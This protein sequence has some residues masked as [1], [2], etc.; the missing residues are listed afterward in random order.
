MLGLLSVNTT[1][2]TVSRMDLASH[3]LGSACL[4][5]NR[6]P[7]TTRVKEEEREEINQLCQ[8][9]FLCSPSSLLTSDHMAAVLLL[10]S[11]KLLPVSD[12]IWNVLYLCI[13]M[14]DYCTISV[15]VAAE[16]SQATRVYSFL[17]LKRLNRVHIRLWNGK[18]QKESM[19][20]LVTPCTS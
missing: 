14:L 18:P 7:G 3:Q 8:L 20:Q 5:Y 12:S 4:P 19:H 2:H 1:D 9:T 16:L 11:F 6:K 17:V 15:S 13:D 10:S